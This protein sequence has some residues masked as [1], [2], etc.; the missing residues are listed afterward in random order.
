[1]WFVVCHLMFRNFTILK[2]HLILN[3]ISC[4]FCD[5]LQHATR[6]KEGSLPFPQTIKRSLRIFCFVHSIPR[7]PNVSW[8]HCHFQDFKTHFF[9][10]NILDRI[11]CSFAKSSKVYFD[12]RWSKRNENSLTIV[13]SVFTKQT[14]LCKHVL[15]FLPHPLPTHIRT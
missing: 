13:A 11:S 6:Y 4:E 2:A 9:P 14:P 5:K 10:L 12:Q 1:M 7:R 8:R 15:T 3:H